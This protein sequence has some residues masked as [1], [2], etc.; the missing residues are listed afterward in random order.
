MLYVLLYLHDINRHRQ[1]KED[2]MGATLQNI[3]YENLENVELQTD[4]MQ[5]LK[6][7]KNNHTYCMKIHAKPATDK[8]MIFSNGAVDP[9]KN[10]PPVYMRSSWSGDIDASAIFIDDPTLHG[11]K[12]RLGWGQGNRDV[13]HREEIAD[14]LQILLAKMNV[15]N[16]GTY[17]FGSS[18]G[19]FMSFYYSI[20]IKGS[21]AV[22]NN[23][24][25]KV[26]NYLEAHVKNMLKKSYG[27]ADTGDVDT[28]L[29]YR[30]D[31]AE[32]IRHHDYFPGKIY[33]FQNQSCEA[34]I[35]NQLNPFI[36]TLKKYGIEAKGLNIISYFD[37]SLG[38]NPIRK[39][40]TVNIINKI[41]N[42]ELDLPI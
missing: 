33:Y 39:N 30:L 9:N 31:I 16:D 20:L 3:D 40:D 37:E 21:T 22:V 36:D 12:L 41:L 18:A 28:S 1:A 2:H 35:E 17:F 26:L 15:E 13:F 14:I 29:L 11:T 23:P 34:D 19:G 10:K 32:A 8:C 4:E 38:H 24:Q 5:E 42:G 6:I 7:K 25:T 27:I